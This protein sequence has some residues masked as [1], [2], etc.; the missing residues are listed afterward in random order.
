MVSHYILP[1]NA[2]VYDACIVRLFVLLDLDWLARGRGG[3]CRIANVT[4]WAQY[5]IFLFSSSLSFNIEIKSKKLDFY[6]KY[7]KILHIFTER[8]V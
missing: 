5:K 4:T 7:F 1:P 8:N 3:A 2:G 6:L